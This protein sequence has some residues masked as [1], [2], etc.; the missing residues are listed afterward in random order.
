M[1]QK[2]T[3]MTMFSCITMAVG[4]II[5]AGLF[6]SLPMGIEMIGGNVGWAFVLATLFIFIR[7][8][9][10]LYLQSSLPV[11]GSTY[12]YLARLI[13]PAVG[14]VQTLNSVIGA[15][16][17]AVMSMTFANYFVQLFPEVEINTTLVA[18]A[19]ALIFT[20]IGTF[21]ANTIGKFQ[22]IIVALL[23][24][25]LG[26]Y[27]FFGFGAIDTGATLQDFIVPTV[28]FASMWGAIAILNYSLQG[29]AIVA[30]FADEVEN[31]GKTIPMSFF[32]GTVIVMILYVIIA[33][34]TYGAGPIDGGYNLGAIAA[35]FMSPGLVR[36]FI[37][38]GALF[39]TITTLNGSLMIYSRVHYA[40]AKDGI[41][42]EVLAK[43][44]KYNVPYVSLWT[45]TVI[46]IVVMLTGTDLGQILRI[47]SIP[48]LLLGVVFYIPP[49]TFAKKFPNAAKKSYIRIPQPINLV[50]C[51]FSVCMSFY[52]GWSLLKDIGS[53][54]IPMAIFYVS[55]YVYYYFRWQ[56]LKKHKGIDIIEKTK[57]ILPQWEE[58]N[59]PENEEVSV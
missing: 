51:V 2:N 5:G 46:A 54:A 53:R 15:L 59:K 56:Y 47:V 39:A 14:Y 20:A 17:I 28:D 42:P 4:A 21:G 43:T 25:A 13:H 24:V 16:N 3:K 9:P 10:S 35:T 27:I 19:C 29:G 36:F 50:L 32:G 40:S 26:L 49:L 58:R 44:N 7:T 38:A 11:S 22:N 48:G 33:F 34:V 52:M 6:T 41:W 31:P 55:G 12:V 57:G 1:S 37:V 45:C 23:M 18:V 8:L 30:S